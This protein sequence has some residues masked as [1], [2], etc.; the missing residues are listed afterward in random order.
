MLRN[1]PRLYSREIHDTLGARDG[2]AMET[3]TGCFFDYTGRFGVTGSTT[4]IHNHLPSRFVSDTKEGAAVTGYLDVTTTLRRVALHTS[5]ASH[6][7]SQCRRLCP[8]IWDVPQS[9]CREAAAACSQFSPKKKTY[10]CCNTS[11]PAKKG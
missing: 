8:M 7:G 11:V 5:K 2:R 3:T 1:H 6:V 4:K 10:K 9:R